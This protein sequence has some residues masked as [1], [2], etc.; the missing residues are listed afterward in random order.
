MWHAIWRNQSGKVAGFIVDGTDEENNDPLPKEYLCEAEAH[1]DL[2]G[3]I[4]YPFIE[5]I[6]L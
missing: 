1:D 4:L 6:E 2:K 3:H 5:L